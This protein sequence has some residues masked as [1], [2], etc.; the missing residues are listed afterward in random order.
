MVEESLGGT[1]LEEALKNKEIYIVNL[2]VL[3]D[4]ACKNCRTV[5]KNILHSF[6]YIYIGSLYYRTV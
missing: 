3:N 6:I 4:I 5:N 1:S 2:D